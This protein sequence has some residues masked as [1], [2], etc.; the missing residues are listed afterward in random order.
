MWS[1]AFVFDRTADGQVIKGLTIVDDATHEAIAIEV[2]RAIPGIGGTRVLNRLAPGRG[3]PQIIRTDN[4]KALV[5][6]AQERGGQLRRI[7]P[8]KP[9]QNAYVESFNGR[10]CDACLNENWFTHQL[11]ARTVIEIWRG[12]TTTSDQRRH[13]ADWR[14]EPM[15]SNWHP[16]PSILDSQSPRY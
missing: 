8:G 14:P 6:W 7:Q 5:T 16:L 1:M 3:L 9:N 12:D 10:L 11:H 2:E 15:R 13:W 4:G